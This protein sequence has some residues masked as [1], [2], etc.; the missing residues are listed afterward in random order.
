VPEV[1]RR[2]RFRLPW[3][4]PWTVRTSA[5]QAVRRDPATAPD[6]R[7]AVRSRLIVCAAIFALWTAGIEARLVYLQVIDHNDL[8][9][10]ADRQQTRTVVLPAKRGEIF[11]RNGRLLAYSVDVDTV[12]ADPS[13]IEDPSRVASSLCSVLEGCN[14]ERRSDMAKKLDRRGAFAYVARQV[15]PAEARKVKELA[16]PGVM[17]LK[18][19]RRY[20]PNAELASHVVGYVGLDNV[21]L[22]GIEFTYD[23][24]IR[25]SDG[26][27]LVQ[28]DAKRHAL[29]S[30]VEHPATAGADLELT[31]DQYLQYIAE[32]EL[33]AGVEANHA[34]GGTAIIMEP[35]SGEIL[36]LANWPTFNPNAFSRVEDDARRNRAIQELYEPG[37]TFK[38]VTASAGLEHHIITPE[39]PIET[40]PGYIT[41]GPRVIHDT[42]QYGLLTFTDVIVKSSNVGAI[43]VGLR[44][45]PQLLGEYVNRF[46]FGQALAPDFRGET[47]GIVWNPDR[48]DASALASVSMGYQVGVTPL[49]MATAVSAI[50]NGGHLVQP[51]VVRAVVKDNKRQNVAHTVLRDAITPETAATLT[52][53][54]EQVVERG[55]AK[56][57]QIPGYTI[58]GKTGTAA[59]LV[60][61]HYQKSDYNAS[62]VGFIPSR[63]PRLT[64]LVVIDS[65]HGNGYTG[66]AVSAPVFKRIAE[67]SLTYLGIPPTINPLP[68]VVVVRNNSND[69]AAGIKK[70]AE[71]RVD[72]DTPQPEVLPSGVMPDLRGLSA[73]EAV[74]LLSRF[75]MSP[76]MSGDGFVISQKPEPG[77]ELTGSDACD[78]RL[79]RRVSLPAAGGS[80][81]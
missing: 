52:T 81:P 51:R 11:D 8:M 75:G 22:G 1:D 76:R 77:V 63:K 56:A 65:P 64:I 57:A 13:A 18:E 34:A 79:G 36:A 49:Q 40:S 30:R 46:G 68:P 6:W 15:S 42:H 45:G 66:G 32:R 17:L 27:V 14:A 58:A 67:A 61:G 20:Y 12:A 23:S 60:N 78:L 16:L 28:T 7:D 26:K 62:F 29:F 33:R 47:A 37:S 44:L 73:R 70:T 54:M 59:K 39:T 25:G 21:G 19:S 35:Q 55:T 31:I 74:H 2:S 50:A 72:T 9:S 38:I 53:I 48:L 41:F 80:P 69:E 43:K 4:L 5:P 24:K 10:R 71:T 3:G